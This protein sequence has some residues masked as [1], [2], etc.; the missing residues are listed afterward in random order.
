MKHLWLILFV[1]PIFSQNF[2]DAE[3]YQK[4]KNHIEHYGYESISSKYELSFIDDNEKNKTLIKNRF[5]KSINYFVSQISLIV[6]SFYQDYLGKIKGSYCPMFPSCSSYGKEIIQSYGY[7]GIL[8]TFDRL[9]RC[10]HD[11]NNYPVLIIDKATR[12]YDPPNIY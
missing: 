11:L 4:I 6:I 12:Y 1:V 5:T 10:S 3:E 2:Y 7:K 8:M 9:N